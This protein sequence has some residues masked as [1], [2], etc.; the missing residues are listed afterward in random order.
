MSS[1]H[2]HRKALLHT[3]MQ[4]PIITKYKPSKKLKNKSKQE[5]RPQSSQTSLYHFQV[6]FNTQLMPLQ[7]N[8]KDTGCFPHL[9]LVEHFSK[10]NIKNTCY[11]SPLPMNSNILLCKLNLTVGAKGIRIGLGLDPGGKGSP[12]W[13]LVRL[14][15]ALGSIPVPR[16]WRILL[17]QLLYPDFALVSKLSTSWHT[18][19]LLTLRVTCFRKS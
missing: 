1:S 6:Y 3:S 19:K 5:N 2:L 4:T 10:R 17:L 15:A 8:E 9:Y 7:L 16:V 11:I 18:R 13:I 14:R 12:T